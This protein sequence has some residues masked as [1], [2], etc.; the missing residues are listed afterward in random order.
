[1]KLTKPQIKAHNQVMELVHSDKKLTEDE[2]YFILDNFQE[3]ALHINSQAGAFFTPRM[4]ARDFALEVHGNRAID[5]CAGIGSLSFAI[6]QKV[7]ELV[8]VEIN[9]DYI[10]IGKR[11]VPSATWIHSSIFDLKDIG[12]FD[13]AV[14]NP[15]FGNIKENSFTGKYSG[16]QFEYKA[17][18]I[19]SRLARYGI[20]ILPQMS[21]SFRYSGAP[22]YKQEIN[23]KCKKFIGQTGIIMEQSCGIDTSVYQDQWNGVS[24]V[25]EIVCC[26]FEEIKNESKSQFDLFADAAS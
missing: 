4:L 16:S 19:A 21:A 25:C 8:C 26:D 3:G 5:L 6:E 7:N 10:E 9:A 17:I 12:L 1:M 15:P 20:F 23:E 18:E 11:I 13:V 14:S 2:K 24:P 22:F